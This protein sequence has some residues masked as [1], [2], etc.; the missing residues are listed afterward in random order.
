MTRNRA[1]RESWLEAAL[2]ARQAELAADW[3]THRQLCHACSQAGSRL[4]LRCADGY[5]LALQLH[6]LARQAASLPRA[7]VGAQG[8]LF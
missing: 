5:G 7:D 6:N 8:A 3:R 2:R 4:A 1:G